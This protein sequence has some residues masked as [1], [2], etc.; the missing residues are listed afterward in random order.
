MARYTALEAVLP[1]LGEPRVPGVGVQ[2]QL[3]EVV[4]KRLDL[5]GLQLHGD[6]SVGFLLVS[7]HH[8]VTICPSVTDKQMNLR[9]S[10]WFILQM[11]Y[12]GRPYYWYKLI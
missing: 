3:Q 5:L 6:A 8:L 10:Y 11:L 9:D 2:A 4:V 7:L 1:E 12:T